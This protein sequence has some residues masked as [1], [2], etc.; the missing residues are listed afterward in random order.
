MVLPHLFGEALL[1]QCAGSVEMHVDSGKGAENTVSLIL[2]CSAR[3]IFFFVLLNKGFLD[4]RKKIAG[5]KNV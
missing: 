2:T 3:E 4:D 5:E 1:Q